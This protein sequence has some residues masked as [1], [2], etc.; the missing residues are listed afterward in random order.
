M[1]FC[2]IVWNS[3]ASTCLQSLIKIAHSHM[4][5][6]VSE[7]V[8]AGWRP[9][10]KFEILKHVSCSAPYGQNFTNVGMHPKI[11]SHNF[12]SQDIDW[13]LSRFLL[14]YDTL[15]D[16]IKIHKEDI[17]SYGQLLEAILPDK[18]NCIQHNRKMTK[19]AN[20]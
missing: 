8:I 11:Q 2:D 14:C 7:I 12:M 9:F 18:F 16:A 15:G 5:S 10:K 17:M 1:T 6:L 13:W 3:A 20:N 19:L 4:Y